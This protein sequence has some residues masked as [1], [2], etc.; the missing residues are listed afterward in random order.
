MV[1]SS[2]AN[3]PLSEQCIESFRP[4]SLPGFF[5]PAHTLVTSLTQPMDAQSHTCRERCG[6]KKTTV[7]G[8]VSGE[9]PDTLFSK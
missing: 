1:D 3:P 8:L 4:A 9:K 5:L 2:L 6:T 7:M